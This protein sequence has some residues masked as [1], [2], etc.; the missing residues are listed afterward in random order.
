MNETFETGDY[1]VAEDFSVVFEIQPEYPI[2][3]Q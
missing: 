1:R 2:A 3:S